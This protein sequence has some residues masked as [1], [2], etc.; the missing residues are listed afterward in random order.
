MAGTTRTL[1]TKLIAI[2]NSR[3]IRIP[4]ALREKYGWSESIMLEETEEGL[5]LRR[6]AGDKLSW[7]ETYKAMAASEED[8][9]D[10]EVATA[11]GIPRGAVGFRSSA[12]ARRRKSRWTRSVPSASSGSGTESTGSRRM[13]RHACGG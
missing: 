4:K 9:R 11:D 8:W 13:S 1:G 5:L 6:D 7:R 3:G 2:G 12:R 10:L